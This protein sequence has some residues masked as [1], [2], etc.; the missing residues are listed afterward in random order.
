MQTYSRLQRVDFEHRITPRTAI[1]ENVTLDAIV[2]FTGPLC[3]RCD[4]AGER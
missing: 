4:F 1:A 2:T 3:S